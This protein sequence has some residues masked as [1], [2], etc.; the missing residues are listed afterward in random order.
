MHSQAR[1]VIAAALGADT[2]HAGRRRR[3]D[4]GIEHG[5]A[6][7]LQPTFEDRGTQPL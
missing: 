2:R 7:M 3:R 1:L 5:V 6:G 4:M